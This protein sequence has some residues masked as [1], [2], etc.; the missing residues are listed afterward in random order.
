VS[1]DN[2]RLSG[3]VVNKSMALCGRCKLRF[4]KMQKRAKMRFRLVPRQT[5][6][7]RVGNK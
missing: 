3:R 2:E 1:D 7:D 6:L 4:K 5:V